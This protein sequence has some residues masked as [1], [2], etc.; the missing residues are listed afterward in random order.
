MNTLDL[1]L[2]VA[3]VLYA[4]SGYR[5]GFLV[6]SAST[7]GLLFGGFTGVRVTPMLLDRFT[8]GLSVSTAALLVVL[9]CAFL[10]Q[11]IGGLI[12]SRIRSRITWRP[13]RVFDALSGAGLSV[14]AMLLIAWVLGVAAS[15][16]QLRT[17]NEEVRGSVVLGAVDHA[18]PGGSDR[19][20]SAFSSLVDSTRFPQYL[21]PFAPER[22]KPVPSPNGA[23][24]GRAGVVA[25]AASVVKILGSADSCGRTLEG[26]GFIFTPGRVMTNAHVVAGVDSPVVRIND[27]DYQA[28]VVYYDPDTDVAVLNAPE[29]QAP[30]LEFDSSAESQE[31]VAVLGFPENG[32]YD[33]EPARVRE[34]KVLRSPN[35]YGDATVYRN[36]YSIYSRVRP[37]NS[38]GPLVDVDGQVV[39]VIFAASVTDPTTGYALTAGQVEAA[40]RQTSSQP[41]DTGACA[42]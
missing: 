41:V 16:T 14:V 35:I 26:S 7:L 42:L 40:A 15:G 5:Q 1:I 24:V 2:V 3:M 12:G 10:G 31:P 38:G 28:T 32:P 11:A 29:L 9:V 4:I 18:L 34:E 25:A 13:A 20:L 17:L 36:T 39:G 22:I 23:V 27:T 21:E 19:L 8:Q 6:G 30:A 37:G 33:A